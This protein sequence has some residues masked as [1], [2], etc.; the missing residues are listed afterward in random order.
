MYNC[1]QVSSL[2][3]SLCILASPWSWPSAQSP[4]ANLPSFC[5]GVIALE[6]IP[7]GNGSKLELPGSTGDES[8]P[9]FRNWEW[10]SW[11]F[12]TLRHNLDLWEA[13]DI[14]SSCSWALH[15]FH[16]LVQLS[17]AV[18]GW[19][20]TKAQVAAPPLLTCEGK[21]SQSR[22][23]LRL[24]F[25]QL[26]GVDAKRVHFSFCYKIVFLYWKQESFPRSILQIS[27]KKVITFVKP[28]K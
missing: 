15:L 10:I 25:Y 16:P 17:C 12:C 13:G 11:N 27:V 20:L 24:S 2:K 22:P 19:P 1:T 4:S 23:S 18:H 3:L 8:S 9:T 21:T 28:I 7:S 14:Q 26:I 6:G 5:S